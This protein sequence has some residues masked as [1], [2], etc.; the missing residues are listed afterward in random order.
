MNESIYMISNLD[1][2]NAADIAGA[3]K[4]FGKRPDAVVT[5]EILYSDHL[6]RGAKTEFLFFN[7]GPKTRVVLLS[8]IALRS[9]FFTGA[10]GALT[11]QYILDGI[12]GGVTGTVLATKDAVSE[13]LAG[14]T[15]DVNNKNT[16]NRGLAKGL[17][18]YSEG[19]FAE[20]TNYMLK[21]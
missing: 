2:N 12:S 10:K 16:C 5:Q 14:A 13:L 15:Q 11:R 7:E 1:M 3:E 9:K 20:F 17:I 4:F 18:G 8:N 6:I 21:N 19:L